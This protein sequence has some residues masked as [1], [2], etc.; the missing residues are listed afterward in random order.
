[1]KDPVV[2]SIVQNIPFSSFCGDE[3][4]CILQHFK[5]AWLVLPT[6]MPDANFHDERLNEVEVGLCLA[7]TK[8]QKILDA[9]LPAGNFFR[10]VISKECPFAPSAW[11]RH[12]H[13]L[14]SKA[15]FYKK[16]DGLI[17]SRGWADAPLVIY[18]Y[19]FTPAT[20]AAYE[21]KR[22]YPHLMVVSRA[23]GIDLFPERH[24]YSYM[25]LRKTSG[26]QVDVLCP[27]SRTGAQ[28]LIDSGVRPD[29]IRLSYL[30]VPEAHSLASPSPDGEVV[31]VSC[32][33]ADSVKR[34][35]LMVESIFAFALAEP[36]T[37]IKW[38][39][40]G[41]GKFFPQFEKIV[42]NR[43]SGLANLRYFLHGH[44]PVETIRTFYKASNIDAFI[45]TS[46]YEGLP[47]SMMEAISAGIPILGT[48]VGGVSELVTEHT[49]ELLPR[50][51]AP[52]DFVAALKRL[53]RF[54]SGRERIVEF[55]LENFSASVNYSK[56]YTD[57]L[58]YSISLSEQKLSDSS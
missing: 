3:L 34:L 19:W 18:T 56:F 10:A 35:D 51:F 13:A 31:L 54:R 22:K 46:L 5:G 11:L 24:K 33:S 50:S 12:A 32:S 47:V 52:E 16:L 28:K 37:K 27:C 57:V 20:Y 4:S 48:D 43:L 58:S 8:K 53:S 26:N 1:M 9:L 17:S 29:K 41:G 23:H 7:R 44:V 36:H 40:F 21:L 25:P 6:D 14:A 38:H 15:F 42:L 2:I 49:G 39:H 30:G 45:S 55:F